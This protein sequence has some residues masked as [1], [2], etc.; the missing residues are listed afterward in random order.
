[1]NDCRY[2]QEMIYNISEDFHELH[3]DYINRKT[4]AKLALVNISGP[5]LT[6]DR[7]DYMKT[8]H[9]M[10]FSKK[11]NRITTFDY[12]KVLATCSNEA[13]ELIMLDVGWNAKITICK[14]V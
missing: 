14:E 9:V 5:I 2:Q 12:K 10:G 7:S 6:I 13:E 3:D 11:N 1:M 8:Y 4:K